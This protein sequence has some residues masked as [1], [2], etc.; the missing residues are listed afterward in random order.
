MTFQIKNRSSLIP[1]TDVAMVSTSI[2][3]GLIVE[4]HYTFKYVDDGMDYAGTDILTYYGTLRPNK[5]YHS[6]TV[7]GIEDSYAYLEHVK[8][9]LK[10]QF[11]NILLNKPANYTPEALEDL[12]VMVN[13]QVA[14]LDTLKH[15]M[16]TFNPD[17]EVMA[18]FRIHDE[19]SFKNCPKELFTEVTPEGTYTSADKSSL[20]HLACM[21]YSFLIP[22]TKDT[23]FTEWADMID[24]RY[25]SPQ[26]KAVAEHLREL[27]KKYS[28]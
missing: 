9:D 16:T 2:Q 28:S 27:V 15:S 10:L 17:D 13:T 14:K 3:C 26:A 7:Y 22:H 1:T 24:S 5:K 25:N 20:F 12:T 23:P 18:V 21:N 11:S 4:G 6:Y 19:I 8:K